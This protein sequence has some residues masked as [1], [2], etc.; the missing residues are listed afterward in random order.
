MMRI[1]MFLI[2]LLILALALPSL[3]LSEGAF[4][5][6]TDPLLQDFAERSHTT[7]DKSMGYPGNEDIR[8]DG[9][10]EWLLTSKASHAI[11]NNVGDPNN[12]AEDHGSLQVEN[13]VI[14]YFAPLY[15]FDPDEVWGLVTMS[16]TDGNNHG[17]YYG[18]NKLISETGMPPSCMCPKNPT[19]PTCGW[20][21][22]SSW[23]SIWSKRMKWAG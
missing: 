18:R 5:P 23:M 7:H 13:A 1:R 21:N 6:E 17:I 2:F 10:Y 9:F 14:R 12:F 22:C 16:G 15:G 19:I 3:C 8:L 4:D 20:R 11:M